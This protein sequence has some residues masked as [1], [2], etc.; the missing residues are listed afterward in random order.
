M[1]FNKWLNKNILPG[2]IG[3]VIWVGRTLPETEVKQLW[4]IVPIT[5]CLYMRIL[6]LYVMYMWHTDS[7]LY[8]WLHMSTNNL[9][10]LQRRPLYYRM[11]QT[12]LY[13]L[14]SLLMHSKVILNNIWWNYWNYVIVSQHFLKI[15]LLRT[16]F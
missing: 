5:R 2:S 6:H 1:F 12:H 11:R 13:D 15:V 7:C 10:K 9:F 16:C 8:H 4:L 3:E 14:L